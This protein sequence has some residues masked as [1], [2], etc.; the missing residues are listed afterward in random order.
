MNEQQKKRKEEV[1][2]SATAAA[3]GESSELDNVV[4][5]DSYRL[6]EPLVE[7]GQSGQKAVCRICGTHFNVGASLG[8]NQDGTF[9]RKWYALCNRHYISAYFHSDPEGRKAVEAALGR[10]VPPLYRD[11]EFNTFKAKGACGSHLA[12]VRDA[13]VGWAK[14]VVQGRQRHGSSAGAGNLYVSGSRSGS[15][16][17]NGCGKTHLAYAAFK[18]VARRTVTSN[19]AC[20]PTAEKPVLTCDIIDIQNVVA[21]FRSKL[22][23]SNGEPVWYNFVKWDGKCASTGYD[24]YVRHVAATPVLIIDDVGQG[25]HADRDGEPGLAG[26]TIDTIA[27]ARAANGLPTL[28]TSNYTPAELGDRVGTRAASRIFRG[29]CKQIRV[30]APDYG[31]T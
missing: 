19:S 20:D 24:D 12:D 6:D 2:A 29:G 18:Y 15:Y 28:Y 3:A 10:L 1:S 23:D 27:D 17:G 9:A 22:A 14:A 5:I 30:E 16:T 21:E 4:G 13:V 25:R 7:T 8:W 26:T 31:M 11:A